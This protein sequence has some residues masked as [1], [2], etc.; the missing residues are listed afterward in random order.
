MDDT[1]M[2]ND[3]YTHICDEI[4]T[5]MNSAEILVLGLNVAFLKAGHPGV[6]LANRKATEMQDKIKEI[7]HILDQLPAELNQ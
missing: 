6:R 2:S 3:L 4:L 5:H 1:K 7:R